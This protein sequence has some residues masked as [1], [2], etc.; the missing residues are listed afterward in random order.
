[1]EHSNKKFLY[2]IWSLALLIVAGI[3]GVVYLGYEVRDLNDEKQSLTDE[4]MLVREESA[5]TTRAH[6]ATITTL[7]E[8]LAKER[9]S[10]IL[11]ENDLILEKAKV[12]SIEE[13][14]AAISGTV[15]VLEKLRRT[16]SELLQKYS[17]VYFLNEHYVP[18]ALSIVE[19][20]YVYDANKELQINANVWPYL[21]ALLTNAEDYKIDLSLVSAYRSFSMQAGLKSAYTVEYGAGTANRFSADQGYSEHQLGTTVDF[22]TKELGANNASFDKTA[23]YKWLVDN[24]YRYGFILSY[25]KGNAYYVYEPWHWRFVGRDLAKKIH[26]EGTHFYDLDQRVINEYLISIFN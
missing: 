17:K 14:V 12:G 16:D 1:M 15:G 25:P 4:L 6:L 7:E 10:R 26:N 24:A 11:A 21:K 20:K 19:P 13:Q 8:N 22:T 3:A 23:S 9:G 18:A 2:T 5:S